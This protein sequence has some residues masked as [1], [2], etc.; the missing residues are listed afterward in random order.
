MTHSG[1]RRGQLV[2]DIRVDIEASRLAN[3][4]TAFKIK[5]S[6]LGGRE[7]KANGPVDLCSEQ[8]AAA[9]GSNRPDQLS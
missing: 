9:G 4:P 2:S 6:P 5:H 3:T 1:K 7:R 8:S